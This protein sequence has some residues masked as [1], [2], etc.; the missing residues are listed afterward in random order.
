MGTMPV[1]DEHP[2]MINAAEI[3]TRLLRFNLPIALSPL[4]QFYATPD[5][6]SRFFLDTKWTRNRSGFHGKTWAV[7][8]KR[9]ESIHRRAVRFIA[10]MSNSS[11]GLALIVG[12]VVGGSN[13]VGDAKL[14]R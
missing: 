6:L 14:F 4:V 5:L 12:S 10:A 7:C 11:T 9:R 8:G 3:K 13:P 1:C 2:A